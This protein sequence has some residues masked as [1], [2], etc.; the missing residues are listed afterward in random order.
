MQ[1]RIAR[2]SMQ[3]G[4]GG[5]WR[6]RVSECF[7]SEIVAQQAWAALVFE[8]PGFVHE[9][10]LWGLLALR[11]DCAALRP[12][13]LAGITLRFI[14]AYLAYSSQHT[15]WRESCKQSIAQPLLF[16]FKMRQIPIISIK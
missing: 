13:L 11:W 6:R 14:P 5:A 4:A 12:G 7:V 3:T 1:G 15:G 2:A 16:H 8:F 10:G 9:G